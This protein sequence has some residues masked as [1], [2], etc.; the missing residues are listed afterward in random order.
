LGEQGEIEILTG[1]LPAAHILQDPQWSPGRSNRPWQPISSLGIGQPEPLGD[2][3]LHAGNVLACR[4]LIRAIE[5][6]RLPEANVYEARM[7]VQMIAGVFESH[8]VGGPVRFPLEN[9]RN[10]LELM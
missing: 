2:G 3:G 10:P 8:R 9:R 4:D 1:H 7:T 5:E 6:D